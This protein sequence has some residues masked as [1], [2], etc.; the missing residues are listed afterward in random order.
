MS[1]TS[2]LISMDH[3]EGFEISDE[4]WD[5][6][7]PAEI[8]DNLI[9][10]GFILEN[11]EGNLIW[12]QALEQSYPEVAELLTAIHKAATEQV[13]ADMVEAEILQGTFNGTDM[14][15]Q[16]TEEG[17]LYADGLLDKSAG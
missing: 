8:I 13:I 15:Y 5:G 1:F 12:G 2:D 10:R 6:T 3:P 11:A 17:K 16:L 14:V 9:Q 7:N 4:V